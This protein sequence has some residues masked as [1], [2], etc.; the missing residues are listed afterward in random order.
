MNEGLL[1][2][3]AAAIA[4]GVSDTFATLVSRRL[5]T[6]PAAAG[7]LGVSFVSLIVITLVMRPAFPAAWSW[8]PPVLLLGGLSGMAYLSLVNAL[9]LGPVSVVAPLTAS[10]GAVV[11]VLAVILLGD[12]PGA[13][14]WLAVAVT[15][16]GAV[17]V[18]LVRTPGERPR[19]NGAGPIFALGAVAGYAFSIIGLQAPIRDVGWLQTLLLWRTANMTVA[20]V[21]LLA[22]RRRRAVTVPALPTGDIVVAPALSRWR[23]ALPVVLVLAGLLESAGQL[24]RAFALEVAPAWLPGVVGPLGPVVVISAGVV[25]FGERLGR[26]QAAGIALVCIGLVLLAVA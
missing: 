14:E 4:F 13:L 15:T 23:L 21:V 20:V 12:R 24:L 2:A 10:T 22:S 5:G 1:F 19:L 16:V 8:A 11:V 9:R 26:S 18:A 7:I 3:V 25:M 6:I 17:L